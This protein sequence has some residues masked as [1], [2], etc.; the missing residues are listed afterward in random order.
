MIAVVNKC[1]KLFIAYVFTSS[2]SA[3]YGE[4]YV[5]CPWIQDR[6]YNGNICLVYVIGKNICLS[7]RLFLLQNYLSCYG[8]QVKHST[9]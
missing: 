2:S 6:Y 1:E 4:L 3:H 7:M 8:N 9:L 5:W